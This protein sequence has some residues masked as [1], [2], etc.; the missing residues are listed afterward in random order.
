[1]NSASNLFYDDVAPTSAVTIKLMG[2]DPQPHVSEDVK[3]I[4]F[5][6]PDQLEDFQAK[7]VRVLTRFAAGICD[8]ARPRVSD[9]CALSIR[10][11][12]VGE[13]RLKAASLSCTTAIWKE[14]GFPKSAKVLAW[15]NCFMADI[16][17]F[18][19]FLAAG[20]VFLRRCFLI[21]AVHVLGR[22]Q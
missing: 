12:E 22:S 13:M 9:L 15:L 20:F 6:D 10:N 3:E 4:V 17:Q 7:I 19:L 1:M 14:G 8:F 2:E 5:E 18:S 16:L 11:I 21:G